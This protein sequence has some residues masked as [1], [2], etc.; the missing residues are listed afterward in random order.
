MLRVVLG[1]ATTVALALVL[2]AGDLATPPASAHPAHSDPTTGLTV[3]PEWGSITG[4]SGRLK[5]GCR[6][7]AFSYAITPPDGVWALE[8]F[9]VAPG[10]K[11]IAAG[12]FLDGYDPTAGTGH[13][14]LCKA[15]TRHGQFRIEA[16]VSTD[17]GSGTI[18]EGQLPPDTYRL[19]KARRR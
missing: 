19:H 9:I 16:K 12:A 3:H 11:N 1:S 6:Q 5:R 15:T 8:V 7:Y 4:H 13:Y 18:T 2:G 14:K 10:D 17:D